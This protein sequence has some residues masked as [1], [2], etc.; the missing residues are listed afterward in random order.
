MS[1]T[2]T[3]PMVSSTTPTTLILLIVLL[4]LL[5]L[6]VQKEISSGLP[7]PRAQRL[8]RALTGVLLVLGLVLI[9]NMGAQLLNL[10]Q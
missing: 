6:L 5:V 9:I 10:P 2:V 1:T 7:D 4:T 3:T 8:S